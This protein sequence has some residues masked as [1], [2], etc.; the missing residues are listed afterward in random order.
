MSEIEL[1]PE[2]LTEQD[3]TINVEM[4]DDEIWFMKHFIKEYNHKKLLK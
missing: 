4:T 3:N 1:I 2:S